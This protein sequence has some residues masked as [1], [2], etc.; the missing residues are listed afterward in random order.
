[1]T[2]KAANLEHSL[3]TSANFGLISSKSVLGHTAFVSKITSGREASLS[4]GCL[5]LRKTSTPVKSAPLLRRLVS[6]AQK[7]VLPILDH[8]STLACL[9]CLLRLTSRR[10]G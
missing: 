8:V 1:M 9:L 6:F 10:R 7:G 3:S 5:R 4:M 2:S